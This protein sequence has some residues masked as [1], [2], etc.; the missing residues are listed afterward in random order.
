M[1]HAFHARPVRHADEAA[2]TLVPS[3]AVQFTNATPFRGWLVVGGAFLVVMV[4]YGAIYSY[5][6][7]AEEIGATFGA[8]RSSVSIVFALSGGSCFFISALTGPLADRIGARVLAA[9]GMVLVGTGLMVAAAA[10]T[11]IEVYIGYGLLIGMGTGFAY[12][13]AIAAVQRWFDAHRG[14]AS[15]I[16]V[17]GVGVGTVLV[18]PA[19]EVLALLGDWRV[20]FAICGI[21]ALLVGLAGAMLLFPLPVCF[22]PTAGGSSL[23]F[24]RAQSR[25]RGGMT[26]RSRAFGL[27]YLG[28]LLVSST[29]T[30]PYVMLVETARSLGISRLEALALLSLIGLGSIA[31]RFMLA[32]L[33]DA[34]GR[35][36]TF[37]GCCLGLAASMVLWALG[38]Q[39]A[40]LQAFALIFGAL[41][42]GFIA[43]LPAFIA[44]AFGTRS[45]GGVLGVLYTSRGIALLA[46]PPV[47][48]IGLRVASEHM[49]PILGIAVAGAVGSALLTGVARA[50]QARDSSAEGEVR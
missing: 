44:D 3:L 11:L 37:L 8:E 7:F 17:S 23:Q 36:G 42:G 27:A 39:L 50:P 14:L 18:A 48:A 38:D 43:L 24:L 26:F 10:T 20:A 49:I 2:V 33:A 30:L 19:A 13:P 35:R 4:G 5:A 12:V 34:V 25:Q 46:A 31:G 32:A 41:H 40:T 47:L 45:V 15:G 6:A 28:T 16:A 9:A 1:G 29:V 21:T 22:G